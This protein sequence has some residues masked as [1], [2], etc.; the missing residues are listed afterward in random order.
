MKEYFAEHKLYTLQVE[1]NVQC[2]QACKFCYVRETVP[3]E[4]ILSKEFVYDVIQQA[5]EMGVKKIEWLG[6]DP[7]RHPDFWSF[8]LRT[9]D[10]QSVETEYLAPASITVKVGHQVMS[11]TV[12]PGGERQSSVCISLQVAQCF[13]EGAG[14]QILGVMMIAHAMVDV[15]VDFIHIGFI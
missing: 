1:I 13:V 4:T 6:G 12:K 10:D 14:G 2:G 9:D 3:K 15:A 7:L 11:A 5:G 8:V